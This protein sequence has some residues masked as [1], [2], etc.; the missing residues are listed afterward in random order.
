MQLGLDRLALRGERLDLGE[1]ELANLGVRIL[2]QL[3]VLG[4]GG[5]D[6]LPA[7]VAFG[8]LAER[9][10][11]LADLAKLRRVGAGRVDEASSRGR[12]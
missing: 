1:R 10:Q 4:E 11:L 5:L 2:E 6:L 12:E 7:G 9:G 3:A 8:R